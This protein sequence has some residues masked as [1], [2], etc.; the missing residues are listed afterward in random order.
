MSETKA[1]PQRLDPI[2]LYD[3]GCAVCR[4]IGRW[5]TA[6][7]RGNSGRPSI[8]AQPVGDDPAAL[9]RLNPELDIWDA[10]A[11]VHVIM[12][13]GSMKTGG[14][15]VAEVLRRLPATR[16]LAP[17]LSI[18]VLGVRPFQ[19][20]LNLAYQVLDD[21]RPL[22]GCDSCGRTRRWVRPLERLVAWAQ[23]VQAQPPT[24]KSRLHFAPL[25]TATQARDAAR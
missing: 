1:M 21:V 14:E 2:L 17:C 20:M 12:P 4:S 3:G 23:P 18:G 19:M 15:A 6:S 13:D 22:L 25:A 24:S 5:V 8:I 10:Y 9:R 7:A 11:V 16:W